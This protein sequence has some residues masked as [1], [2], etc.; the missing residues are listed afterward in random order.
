[1]E[2]KGQEKI[3]AFDTLFTNN[4]IQM[5]KILL[6]FLPPSRQNK[7][8]IYIKFLELQYTLQFLKHFPLSAV[9]TLNRQ[10]TPA[11]S[12]VYTELMPFCSPHEQ[13]ILQNMHDTI[14]NF[15]NMQEILQMFHLFQEATQGTEDPTDLM[16]ALSTFSDMSDLKD[17]DLSQIFQL[18]Q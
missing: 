4:H 14:K 13:N 12:T 18:L 7:L 6:T 8:A 1:M 5:L 16:S 2:D 17:M 10:S 3:L 9:N 11:E 15:E